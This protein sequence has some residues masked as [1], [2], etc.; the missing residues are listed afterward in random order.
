MDESKP[1]NPLVRLEQT[2]TGYVASLQA[3]KGSIVGRML[4]NRGAVD[5]LAVNDLY[6]RLIESPFDLDASSELSADSIFVA[7]EKFLNIAWREQMGPIMTIQ[8]LDTLQERMNKQVPGNFADFVNYMFGDMA[9]Q[10]RRAFTALIK[11]LADLLEGCSNDSDRGAITVAFAELLVVDGTAH[12]YINLL[13]RLVEDCDRIFEDTSFGANLHPGGSAYESMNSTTRSTKSHTG[14]LTSNTSSIRRKF[15]LDSLLRQNSKNEDRPSVWRTLSK[16]TRNPATGDVSQTASLSRATASRTRSIDMGYPGPNKLKRPNARDR[17][18]LAG[19]FDDL[20][21]PGSSH[22]LESR[23]ETIGEPDHEAAAHKTPKKK[24]RS[25]L[26]DLRSLMAA[27]S[28]GDP[29][30]DTS[31]LPL[32]INKQ[33][34]EK[35]NSTPRAK[36]PTPSRIPVSPNTQSLRVPRPQKENLSLADI[37]QPSPSTAG[38]EKRPTRGHHSKNFSTSQI[39]TLKPA[40]SGLGSGG[41]S[42]TRPS[43][44]PTKTGSSGRLRLQSPQKLRERL[45]TEKQA[46]DEVDASLKSELSKIAEEMSRVN[47]GL[48]DRTGTVDLRRLT[49]SVTA[50]EERVPTM[51]GELNERHAAIQRDMESTL[52]AS[53]AKVKAI[54]QL[55]RE[56]TAENELLYEKF[57]SELGKIVKALRG[58]G[59]ED[60]EE[61]VSK[62]REQSEESAKTKRENARLRREVISL[63]TA[64]KGEAAADGA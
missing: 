37:F 26:S 43:L 24:R 40:R 29:A 54:D 23:L 57:N 35:F 4:L 12:N 17:P 13:D 50:L 61:L 1:E 30:E 58:K 9:P 64:L 16:H 39:P 21:R 2:F 62:L 28:L 60:K 38:T 44:S 11:L 48:G 20:Q 46:V 7:F 45:Q 27:A 59:R 56:A 32:S 34:S 18:P 22:K 19:A 6:N 53:E 5:E 41:E 3:R 42:P 15:G 36:S 47:N 10:N 63:R 51:L 33:I 31:I 25:S 8:A 49:Q 14:S 55:Y 52:K